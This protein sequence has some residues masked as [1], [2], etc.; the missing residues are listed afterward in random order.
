M[1]IIGT[2]LLM[3]GIG[4][5]VTFIWSAIYANYQW[6]NEVESNWSLADKTSTLKAKS[7]Y[8]DKFILALRNGNLAD[9]DALIYKTANNNCENNVKA[10]ETLKQ[11]LDEISGMDVTSF[12]YQQAIQQITEQE[13]GQATEMMSSLSGCWYKT[14]HYYLWNIFTSFGM[15]LLP[16]VL[17]IIGFMFLMV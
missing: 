10:V 5:G 9:N 8:I 3:L 17:I 12:Q 15:L 7:E 14:Y 6:T 2:I 16:I 4:L 1:K 13:Q 11:R